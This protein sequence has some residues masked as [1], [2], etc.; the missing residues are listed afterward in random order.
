VCPSGEDIR[1]PWVRRRAGEPDARDG[2]T[3]K[4]AG[5]GSDIRRMKSLLFVA[6]TSVLPISAGAQQVYHPIHMLGQHPHTGRLKRCENGA[7]EAASAQN[8]FDLAF[9]EDDS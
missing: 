6:L 8:P 4:A 1:F 5:G 7:V 2:A 3:Q 9:A